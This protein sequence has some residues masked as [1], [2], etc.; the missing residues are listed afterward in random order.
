MNRAADAGHD[1]EHQETEGIELDADVDLKIT[2]RKPVES[3]F[4]FSFVAGEL[5]KQHRTQNK[6]R[7]DCGNGNTRAQSTILLSEKRDDRCRKER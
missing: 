2:N 6:R 1:E 5:K 3:E 7:D 4:G